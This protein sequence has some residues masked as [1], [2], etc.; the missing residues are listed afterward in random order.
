MEELPKVVPEPRGN[1][2]TVTTFVGALYAS[3]KRTRRYH[4]GY[5]IFVNRAPVILYIKQQSTVES[6]KFSSEFI[7]MKTCRVH[8][9]ALILKLRMFVVDI[10]GPTIILNDN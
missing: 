1:L 10:D 6:S 5:V 8:I 3:D 9:I 7:A 4:T 2:V